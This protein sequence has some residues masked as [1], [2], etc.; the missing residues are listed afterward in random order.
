MADITKEIIDGIEVI[1]EGNTTIFR[2]IDEKNNEE[3]KEIK[4][5]DRFWFEKLIDKYNDMPIK[6]YVRSRDLSDPFGDSDHEYG[7]KNSV[8]VGINISF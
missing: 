6:P 5:D 8:E 2:P 7:R 4:Y 3:K 1:H